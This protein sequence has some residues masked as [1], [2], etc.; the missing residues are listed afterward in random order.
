M[1]RMMHVIDYYSEELAR[2]FIFLISN[3]K[4]KAHRL[5]Y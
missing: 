3:S 4:N 1:M 5:A 2:F